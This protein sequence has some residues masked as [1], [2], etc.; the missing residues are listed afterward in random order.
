MRALLPFEPLAITC[1]K[2]VQVFGIV[3]V[4]TLVIAIIAPVPHDEILV[5]LREYHST[6]GIKMKLGRLA[7]FM[8]YVAIQSRR[9]SA[10]AD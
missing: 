4:E 8:T 9:I 3:A 1:F 6:F 2:V 5:L 7:A 10:R